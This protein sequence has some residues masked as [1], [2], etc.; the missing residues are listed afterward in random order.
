MDEAAFAQSMG[1]EAEV[2]SSSKRNDTGSAAE[3]EG[4]EGKRSDDAR[5]QKRSFPTVDGE[6]APCLAKR[7]RTDMPS[8]P[9]GGVG[10]L[11]G[12]QGTPDGAAVDAAAAQQPM[13][14]TYSSPMPDDPSAMPMR[15]MGED[16]EWCLRFPQGSTFKS[17][18]ENI[19]EILPECALEVCHDGPFQGISVESIDPGRICLLQGRLSGRVRVRDASRSYAFCVRMAT[20]LSC[21]RSIAPSYFV[22]V[23]NP[24]DSTDIVIHIYEPRVGVHAPRFRIKTLAKQQDTC[25]LQGMQ[26]DLFVE[27]DLQ[28]F[29]NAVKTA[30]DHR[31]DCIEIAVFTPSAPSPDPALATHFFVISYEGD[32]A[33]CEY[34]YQSTTELSEG[35]E[36]TP[37]VIKATE[38]NSREFDELPPKEDLRPLYR[39][40][41][42]CDCIAQF[43]KSLER[44]A[45]TLRMANNKPLV[46]DHP[47]GSGAVGNG[48]G[49]YLRLIVAPRAE[50]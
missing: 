21:L 43:I 27:V 13:V 39:G 37:P 46:L 42:S 24:V 6:E 12:E 49:D 18:M 48:D 31:A 17:F 10:S 41:F 9:G 3:G 4:T 36:D 35:D 38:A 19:K 14:R 23:W 20:V 16:V 34:A 32:E 40:R 26:F 8:R 7:S 29:R 30:R 2:V 11:S 1:D 47:I 15:R 44:H 22:D 45:L 25:E 50:G 28:T 33:Q 5:T